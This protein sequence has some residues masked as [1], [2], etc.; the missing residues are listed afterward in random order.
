MSGLPK[1]SFEECNYLFTALQECLKAEIVDCLEKV[2]S[3]LTQFIIVKK[4]TFSCNLLQPSA[5]MTP[6]YS[7]S[8]IFFIEFR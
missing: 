3:D 5:G 8:S 1:H 4:S 7:N 6:V 2:Q